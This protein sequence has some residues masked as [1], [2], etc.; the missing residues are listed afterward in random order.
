[1]S[2]PLLQPKLL[3]GLRSGI[4]GNAQF[5]SDEEIVYPVG[6][7]LAI[8]NYNLRKQKFIKLPERGGNVTS[9]TVSP[10]K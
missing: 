8:H 9:I 1:M 10:N 4:K 2:I 6:G 7:V 3:L 5:I